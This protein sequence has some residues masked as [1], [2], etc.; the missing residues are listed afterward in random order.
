MRSYVVLEVFEFEPV[1]IMA[2]L[3]RVN[4]IQTNFISY[5]TGRS[6]YLLR[7]SSQPHHSLSPRVP[8]K[9]HLLP[10]P[11]HRHLHLTPKPV[12]TPTIIQYTLFTHSHSITCTCRMYRV[13]SESPS[14]ALLVSYHLHVKDIPYTHLFLSLSLSQSVCLSVSLSV[15]VSP[16]LELELYYSYNFLNSCLVHSVSSTRWESIKILWAFRKSNFPCEKNINRQF[17]CFME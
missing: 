17:A 4:W 5:G 11:L 7:L 6:T 2:T 12:G 14:E 15:S 16:S 13:I 10:H 9:S 1:I 3:L 8:A